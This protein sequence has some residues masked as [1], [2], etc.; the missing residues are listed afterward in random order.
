MKTHVALV[1]FMAA[2]KTT[3]GRYLARELDLPFIDTDAL[4]VARHGPIATIFTELGEAT[5]RSYEHD[6]ILEALAGAPSVVALGGGAVTDEG[7]RRLVAARAYRVFLDVPAEILA[8]RVR[9]SPT[10]RPVVGKTPTTTRIRE[11]LA[12]RE[13][14]YREADYTIPGARRSK[15]ALAREIAELI[16]PVLMRGEQ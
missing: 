2:G 10:L 13:P 7:T 8:T 12:Q 4:I 9:R 14:L 11:L 3:I 15:L 6:A 5:F 16:R 1:G